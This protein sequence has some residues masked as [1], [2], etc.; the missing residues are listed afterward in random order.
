MKRLR[1]QGLAPSGAAASAVCRSL[2]SVSSERV[3]AV[4]DAQSGGR[5]SI[6]AGLTR[7]GHAEQV[8]DGWVEK[9]HGYTS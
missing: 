5:L 9:A 8:M 3:A 4:V 2:T 1:G 7:Y 6:T